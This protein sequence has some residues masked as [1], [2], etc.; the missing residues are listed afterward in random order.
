MSLIAHLTELRNRVAKALLALLIGT[1]S[2]SGGTTTASVEFIRARTAPARRPALRRATTAAAADHRR[3]RRRLHPPQDRLHRRAP[4]CPR[5]SGCTRLGRSSPAR[6]LKRTEER[7]TGS[8]SSPCSNVL[9]AAG[10]QVLSYIS[11]ARAFQLLLSWP[12]DGVVVRPPA[13]GLHRV[14]LSCWSRSA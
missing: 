6:A 8:A 3:L 5:R 1:A 14:V 11:L 13:Q 12:G 10:L 4:C 9:F 7:D 2:P